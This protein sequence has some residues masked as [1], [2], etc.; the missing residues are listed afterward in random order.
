MSM[1]TSDTLVAEYPT[2]ELLAPGTLPRPAWIRPADW[3]RMP[4]SAQWK[5]TRRMV[6]LAL[7]GGSR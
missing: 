5:A 3:A 2:P 6:N 7:G 4:W 1:P